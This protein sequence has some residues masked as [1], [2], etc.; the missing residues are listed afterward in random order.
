MTTWKDLENN[1]DYEDEEDSDQE[2]QLCLMADHTDMD[3]CKKDNEALRA[4]NESLLEK[5]AETDYTSNENLN[6]ARENLELSHVAAK[7]SDAE[8]IVDQDEPETSTQTK[9]LRK[10]KFLKNYPEEF[11]IGDPSKRMTTRSFLKRD[12]SNNIALI[13]KIEP[14]NIQEVLAGPS[15]VLAMTE[16]LQ[17]FK[18]S[19]VW[20]LVS[21]SNGKKVTNFAKFMTSEFDMSIMGELTFFLGLQIKQIAKGIFVHQEKYA[22][23]IVKKFG[24]ECANIKLDKYEHARYVDETRYK[25][26]IGFLMQQQRCNKREKRSRRE[27][28]RN[29]KEKEEGRTTPVG[30]TAAAP[31]C[32]AEKREVRSEKE[33]E[34]AGGRGRLLPQPSLFVLQPVATITDRH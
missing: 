6:S 17:H 1:I 22:K 24:L 29:G 34:S 7:N 16:K 9:R 10:W 28:K 12:E 11:I 21:H 27:E 26:M 5:N 15:W 20:N 25:E 31:S 8:A 13:S 2:A 4:E 19:H 3:E 32:H 18:K 33:R 23:E 14:Q 30:V